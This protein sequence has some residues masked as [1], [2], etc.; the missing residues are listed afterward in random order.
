MNEVKILHIYK[1]STSKENDF[2]E[3]YDEVAKRVKLLRRKIFV[4]RY[5]NGIIC[6]SLL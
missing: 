6:N 1:S 4:K 2:I 5:G 3:F